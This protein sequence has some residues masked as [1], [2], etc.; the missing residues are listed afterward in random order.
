MGF[1]H[2]RKDATQMEDPG[3]VGGMGD[4]GIH[5][6]ASGVRIT[7]AVRTC[8]VVDTFNSNPRDLDVVEYSLMSVEE[9]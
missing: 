5:D 1:L 8:L 3:W 9:L 7:I 2:F 4:V 6:Q